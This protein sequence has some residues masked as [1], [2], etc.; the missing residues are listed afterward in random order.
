MIQKI[1]AWM[2][3]IAF[4]F[5]GLIRF[6]GGIFVMNALMVDNANPE[7]TYGIHAGAEKVRNSIP[8][9]A[10]TAFI[11][12]NDVGYMSYIIVMGAILIIGT[13]ATLMKKQWGVWIMSS[14]FV[15]YLFLKKYVL[16]NI[17][18]YMHADYLFLPQ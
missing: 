13:I 18:L 2:L 6:I 12:F 11:P 8:D 14:Y 17:Q 4:I 10:E 1:L 5:Y 7:D 16:Y 15:L 9:L 3:G